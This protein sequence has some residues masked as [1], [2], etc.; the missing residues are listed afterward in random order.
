M[1]ILFGFIVFGINFSLDL[2]SEDVKYI[3]RGY[4]KIIGIIMRIFKY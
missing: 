4:I 1:F 2:G 3:L